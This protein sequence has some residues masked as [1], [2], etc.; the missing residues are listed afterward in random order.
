M[1]LP[2]EIKIVPKRRY[3]AFNLWPVMRWRQN[4]FR[5]N[6]HSCILNCKNR[7]IDGR[8]WLDRVTNQEYE[9]ICLY[10]KRPK[11]A[12]KENTDR[13]DAKIIPQPLNG[14]LFDH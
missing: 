1:Y 7:R 5:T 3:Q 10:F 9:Y 8:T 12:P 4:C 13:V 11:N 2:I 6:L 14:K